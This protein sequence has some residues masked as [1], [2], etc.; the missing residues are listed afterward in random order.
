[1]QGHEHYEELCALAAGGQLSEQ[2]YS[3]LSEHLRRC[4]HCNQLHMQFASVMETRLPFAAATTRNTI[5]SWGIKDTGYL[6]RFIERARSEGI[7]V[8]RDEG[9]RFGF[10]AWR[11]PTLRPGFAV[12]AL[13][14][15]AVF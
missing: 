7:A 12:A 15:A 4:P 13:A 10:S 8:P 3:D 9:K 11:W 2:E 5:A 1:M 14:L 6:N